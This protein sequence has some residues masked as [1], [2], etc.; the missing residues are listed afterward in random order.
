[1]GCLRR[2]SFPSSRAQEPSP[3]SGE[4][5]FRLSLRLLAGVLSL[6][7]I[8]GL[9]SA[10]QEFALKDGD[11]VVFYGDSITERRIYSSFT[12]A[13]VLTRFPR[14]KVRFVHSGWAG[15]TV[16][17]GAGGSLQVRL[18]RDVI[19]YQ[20][21]VVT[22]LLGMND[23]HY[24]ALDKTTYGDFT[25]GYETL[26]KIL[27]AALPNVRL[28]LLDL[29]LTTTSLGRPNSWEAITES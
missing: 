4:F 17:G 10:Q 24:R 14:L 9:L 29:L 13:Y 8:P 5:I 25:T 16:A 19:A 15:D 23:G 3:T 22:I 7:C 6:A 2:S 21:T 27:K 26:I 12:E 20:P 18:Q 1:M 28:T 11:T